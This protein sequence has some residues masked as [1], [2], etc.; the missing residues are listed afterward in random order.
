MKTRKFKLIKKYPNS[1]NVGS[2]WTKIPEFEMYW[3]ENCYLGL[4]DVED[5]PEFFEE[6]VTND[7]ELWNTHYLSLKDVASIYPGINKE[8]NT[9]SH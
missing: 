4:C 5:N 2:I 9:P 8:H 6:V 1:E 3:Y 7:W